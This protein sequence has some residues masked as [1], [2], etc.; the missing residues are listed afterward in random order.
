MSTITIDW[1]QLMLVIT[2]LFVAVGFFRGFAREVF[3]SVV[4]LFL[5]YM[6]LSPDAA[7]RVIEVANNFLNL[8]KVVILNPATVVSPQALFRAY[9]ETGPVLTEQ[10]AYTFFLIILVAM[11]VA[12]YVGGARAI[13]SEAVPPLGRILGGILGYLNGQMIMSLVKDYLLGNFLREPEALTAQGAIPQTLAVEI[14]NVPAQPMFTQPTGLLVIAM[15]II[16]IMLIV[17]GDRFGLRLPLF[18][19]SG[20]SGS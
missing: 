16:I 11:L 6:I 5:N 2:F 10:N 17:L 9:T 20:R 18:R 15:T 19:R 12:S 4:L 7:R 3:T 8:F 13:G 1:D 14:Q